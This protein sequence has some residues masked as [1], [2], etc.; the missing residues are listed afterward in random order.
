MDTLVATT[1]WS[2]HLHGECSKKYF[3]ELCA[4]LVEE[5][6]TTTVYPPDDLIF[7][8][9]RSCPLEL[10]KV[11]IL[12]QDPYIREGQANGLAFS[13][14]K[15]TSIPPSLR[16]IFREVE[17]DLRADGLTFGHPTHGDLH[18]WAKQ[19]VLLLN[20]SLTVRYLLV[21]HFMHQNF[22]HNFRKGI[23]DSHSGKGWEIFTDAIVKLVNERRK[24]VVFMLWG[25]NAHQKSSLI[26]SKRHHI[27]KAAHPSPFSA[28]SGFF[29]CRHFTKANKLLAGAGE[30][31]I[32]WRLAGEST[33]QSSTNSIRSSFRQTKT[34]AAQHDASPKTHDP[35]MFAGLVFVVSGLVSDMR[36]IHSDVKQGGGTTTH[37]ISNK[38]SNR[39]ISLPPPHPLLT[40]LL[41][42]VDNTPHHNERGSEL[43]LLQSKEST[44]VWCAYCFVGLFIGVRQGRKAI[45]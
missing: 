36:R 19:G 33:S 3:K 21:Q 26:D 45:G 13:V 38:V 42:F 27:L 15:Q 40:S 32:D 20:T 37:I 11:V 29:G 39:F 41:F 25:K 31:P 30:E 24:N 43:G 35:Q 2:P 4:F 34:E 23:P 44:R 6:K 12:G 14:S 7:S 5:K 8:A 10:V 28:S 9:L 16:N 22:N 17:S 18:S 1:P